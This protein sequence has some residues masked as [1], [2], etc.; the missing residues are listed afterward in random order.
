MFSFLDGYKTYI[1][2]IGLLLTA[3]AVFLGSDKGPDALKALLEAVFVALGLF[4]L[5]K[6]VVK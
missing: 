2:A 6:A 4:G 1:A 3:I 5:R